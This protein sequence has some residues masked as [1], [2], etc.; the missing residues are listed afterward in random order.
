MAGV[1]SSSL[2]K[3]GQ[4]RSLPPVREFFPEIGGSRNSSSSSGWQLSSL[5]KGAILGR[6]FPGEYPD[7]VDWAWSLQRSG[8]ASSPDRVV[9]PPLTHL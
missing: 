3:T 8:R 9:G 4:L 5:C 6:T 2:G 1:G 7:D